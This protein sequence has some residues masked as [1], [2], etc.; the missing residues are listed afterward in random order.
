MDDI[1]VVGPAEADASTVPLVSY[2]SPEHRTP[3]S[4]KSHGNNRHI[5][6]RQG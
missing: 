1:F 3:Q 2:D 6:Y 4:L 5:T